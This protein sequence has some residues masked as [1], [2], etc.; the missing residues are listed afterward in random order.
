M[1]SKDREKRTP[2]EIAE[3]YRQKQ[4]RREAQVSERDARRAAGTAAREERREVSAKA[5]DERT[6][7]KMQ[8]RSDAYLKHWKKKLEREEERR[9]KN[10]D[11]RE[12]SRLEARAAGVEKRNQHTKNVRATKERDWAASRAAEAKKHRIGD[13]V[14]RQINAARPRSRGGK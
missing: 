12:L 1:P 2:E 6:T 5:K 14:V 8:K 10:R 4:L 3:H 7:E 13:E 11:D 9:L